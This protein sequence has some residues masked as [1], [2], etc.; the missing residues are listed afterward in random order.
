M[1][2]GVIFISL[3]P[4]FSFA[5]KTIVNEYVSPTLN[6]CIAESATSLKSLHVSRFLTVNDCCL[7]DISAYGS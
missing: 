4:S 6:S 7:V 5:A 2:Y 1:R 3:M